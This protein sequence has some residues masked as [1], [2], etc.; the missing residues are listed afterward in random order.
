LTS[1]MRTSARCAGSASGSLTGL[2]AVLQ[3]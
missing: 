2:L 3:R 1:W